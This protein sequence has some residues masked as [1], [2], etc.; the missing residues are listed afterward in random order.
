[1]L[2]ETAEVALLLRNS[3]RP[4]PQREP[5]VFD[6]DD[7]LRDFSPIIDREQSIIRE[8]VPSLT[9]RTIPTRPKPSQFTNITQEIVDNREV[10]T[11]VEEEDE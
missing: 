5:A 1:M 11:T 4:E 6:D 7:F 9:I 2:G 3:Q 10:V 8:T